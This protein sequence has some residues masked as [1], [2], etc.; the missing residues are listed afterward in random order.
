MAMFRVGM[1]VVC[2]DANPRGRW[3]RGEELRENG[4]YT[5]TAMHVDDDADLI[6][7]LAEVKRSATA[8]RQWRD[9]R[10]GYGAF[11]FRPIQERK[12]DI[13]FAHEILRKVTKKKPV[14]ARKFF[15][16]ADFHS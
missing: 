11:R 3:V 2:V 5:I 7:H 4:V 8:K 10:L 16:S 9:A 1:K 6:L 15:E 12:T 13:S 14:S